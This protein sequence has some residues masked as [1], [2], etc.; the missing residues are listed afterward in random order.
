MNCD[1]LLK[2]LN[3]LYVEDEKKLSELMEEAIAYRFGN[4]DTAHDGH[5]GLKLFEKRRADIVITDITMPGMDGLEMT[6]EIHRIAP[7]TAVI[8]LSA[9]SDRD[10]LLSA[11]EERVVKYFIKPFDPEEI[12]EYIC[13]IAREISQKN[14]TR[15]GENF[16]YDRENKILLK[17]GETVR[18]TLRE[19]QFIDTL[20]HRPGYFI[21]KEEIKELLWK[22][23]ETT[24]DAV[25]VF[26]KRLRDKTEG[27]FIKNSSGEGYYLDAKH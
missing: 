21:S 24:D 11:I 5:E 25:R 8:I 15:I 17:S 20:I 10:K 7:D 4:F 14:H 27:D 3:L 9:Y 2:R 13:T 6:R 26:V 16:L 1:K 12:L 19:T 22:G 18:L 23:T